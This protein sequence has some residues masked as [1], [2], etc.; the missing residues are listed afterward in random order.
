MLKP[1]DGL[2]DPPADIADVEGKRSGRVDLF[3]SYTSVDRGWAEWIAWQLELSGYRVLIQA[4]DFV[5]GSHWMSRMADGIRGS[6]RVL[7]VL[8][9]A[10]LNSVYG[11]LEWQAAFDADPRGTARKV[12]P[13]RI[14]DCPRPELLRGVVSFDLFGLTDDQAKSQLDDG[15]RAAMAGRAKP[16][17]EPYFPGTAASPGLFDSGA[18]HEPGFPGGPSPITPAQAETP[19]PPPG[20]QGSEPPRPAPAAHRRA[21]MPAD[22]KT[23]HGQDSPADAAPTHELAPPPSGE[24]AVPETENN[25]IDTS[26]APRRSMRDKAG[27][28]SQ[29]AAPS[30]RPTSLADPKRDDRR[31]TASDATVTATQSSPSARLGPSMLPIEEIFDRPFRSKLTSRQGVEP[32]PSSVLDRLRHWTSSGRR[33]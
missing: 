15:I 4:W 6:D 17:A 11:Q 1:V 26:E 18:Q 3:V 30:T 33:R 29:S 19:H 2:G 12:I 16:Q 32:S 21:L 22:D 24:P 20:Q 7:A 5:P 10:Y 13:I 31:R 14:E 25:S 27:P 28:R 23:R 9:H 8:S